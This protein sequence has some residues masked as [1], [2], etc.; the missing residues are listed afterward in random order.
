MKN[1]YLILLFSAS[2]LLF[3]CKSDNITGRK[4]TPVDS[5]SFTYPFTNGSSW[6]YTYTATIFNIR[7]D[8]IRH[9]FSEYPINAIGSVAILYDTVIN[10]IQLKCFYDYLQQDTNYVAMRTY[11]ANTDSA[12]ISYGYRAESHWLQ[13]SGFLP[14]NKTGSLIEIENQKN[15]LIGSVNDIPPDSLYMNNPPVICMK[16]PVKT[17]VA[18][19]YRYLPPRDTITRKYIDFENISI[20]SKVISCV[21]TRVNWTYINNAAAY[22]YFSKYGNLKSDFTINDEL[23]TDEFGHTLGYVSIEEVNIVTAYNIRNP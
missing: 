2:I 17:G 20:G 7:P 11:Y 5:S 15:H 18:W 16:Y 19:V 8:S 9:Y 14:G 23:V 13:A 3:S 6:N 1:S 22:N 21:K 4:Y 10:G 12:L